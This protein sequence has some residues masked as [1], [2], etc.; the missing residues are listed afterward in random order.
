MKIRTIAVTAS[1]LLTVVHTATPAAA[2]PSFSYR[3]QS[4]HHFGFSFFHDVDAAPVQERLPDGFN[5]V[6]CRPERFP[7]LP[8]RA[9]IVVAVKEEVTS[10]LPGYLPE[11][12]THLGV[13]TCATPPDD[14]R[15]WHLEGN[16]QGPLVLLGGWSD[17]EAHSE[18]E[19]RYGIGS[20]VAMISFEDSSVSRSWT[21]TARAAS[22]A[23]LAA[24]NFSY[25]A[26][27]SNANC[28]M[29]NEQGRFWKINAD[30]SVGAYDLSA[31]GLKACYGS[32][33][34]F[35]SD[36][37]TLLADLVGTQAV[38]T[39]SGVEESGDEEIAY[40]LL[41]HAPPGRP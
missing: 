33:T 3:A 2:N 7:L 40:R 31:P 37:G 24:A 16:N 20:E 29:I 27:D 32:P 26:W 28:R 39:L 11:K 4:T 41:F 35:S 1:I 38:P 14:G 23:L 36:E 17:S 22:G 12:V 10:G 13:F 9:D 15:D 6:A 19:A 8:G 5:I 30:G 18:F 25:P 21:F 34:T